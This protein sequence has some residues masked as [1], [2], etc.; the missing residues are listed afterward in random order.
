MPITRMLLTGRRLPASGFSHCALNCVLAHA[1]SSSAAPPSRASR[2]AR[3]MGWLTLPPC[4][5]VALLQRFLLHPEISAV[6]VDPVGGLERRNPGKARPVDRGVGLVERRQVTYGLAHLLAQEAQVLARQVDVRLRIARRAAVTRDDHRRLQGADAVH[7]SQPHLAVGIAD[8]GNAAAEVEI[9]GDQHTVAL[10]PQ[11]DVF[12]RVRA[13]DV[14]QPEADA[15]AL[16]RNLP[17]RAEVEPARGA[18]QS[19]VLVD[20]RPEIASPLL[21]PFLGGR[22]ADRLAAVG[23][24]P[25]LDA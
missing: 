13:G 3:T 24:P 25:D 6:R 18:D 21:E 15:A 7:R 4:G 19:R 20:V 2:A 14:D 10:D 23:V 5:A 17:G 9:A 16:E 11:H 8:E 1:D 22:R 12:G